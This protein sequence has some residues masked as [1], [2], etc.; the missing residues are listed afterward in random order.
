MA[1]ILDYL[2][3]R[4]DLPFEASAFNEVDAVVF[5]RFSYIPFEGIVPDD[6]SHTVTVAEAAER[7][8]GDT[9]RM[10]QV[11][12][13]DDLKLLAAMG[14]SRRFGDL[15]LCGYENQLDEEIQ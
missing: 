11:I 5:S 7:F 14:A 6:F 2:E 12:Y 4:G 13:E 8:L 3:W 1:N 15:L 10:T 9:E